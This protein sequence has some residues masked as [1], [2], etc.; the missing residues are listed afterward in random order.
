MALGTI[1]KGDSWDGKGVSVASLQGKGFPQCQ[2]LSFDGGRKFSSASVTAPGSQEP[3]ANTKSHCFRNLTWRHL[4]G[5]KNLGEGTACAWVR[6][7]KELN[8]RQGLCRV[9]VELVGGGGGVGVG[10]LQVGLGSEGL[11]G[12]IVDLGQVCV[13]VLLLLVVVVVGWCLA[14]LRTSYYSHAIREIWEAGPGC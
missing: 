3:R 7:N 1:W 14:S 4:L 6:S 2:V 11:Y 8:R 10:A 13:C 12:P 9:M 5:D